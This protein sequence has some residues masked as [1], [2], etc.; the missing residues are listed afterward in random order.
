MVYVTHDQVEA[1]TLADRIVVLNGG[2]VE[3]KG[4]PLDL[5]HQPANL[6]VAGFIGSPSMNFLSAKAIGSDAGG[7]EV[8]VDGIG[9]FTVPVEGGLNPGP[10]LTLGIRPHAFNLGAGQ[11]RVVM[12]P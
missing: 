11:S 9:R 12:W 1:M 7:I 6:F 2:R 3:Q 8:E 10:Q 4:A 5:Y